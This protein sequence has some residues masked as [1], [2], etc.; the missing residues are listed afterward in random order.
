MTNDSHP[1][2]TTKLKA[3]PTSSRLN[4]IGQI[5]P[6]QRYGKYT[7][8]D[9]WIQ[10][11][12]SWFVICRCDC[13]LEKPQ[14]AY[15][16]LRTNVKMCSSCKISEQN[17]KHGQNTQQHITYEYHQWINLN[18][19]KRLCLEWSKSF[20]LFFKDTGKRPEKGFILCKIR[21]NNPLGKNNFYWGHPRN[22]FFEDIKGH[23]FG[24]WKILEKDFDRK[25]PSW[26]CQCSCGRKDY[27]TQVNLIKGISTKCKSC[28]A[29][30]NIKHNCSNN[31]LYTLFHSI[32]ARCYNKNHKNYRHYGG[33]GI[34]ICDRWL[35]SVRF[36]IEDMGPRPSCLH[37]IDRIDN[38]GNYCP[39]NCRWAT[40]KEQ[41]NNRRRIGDMQK[42]IDQLK[43]QLENK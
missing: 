31:Y 20:K 28:A 2:T 1:S 14:S 26:L 17:F 32:K 37:S 41:T 23:V 16:L 22:R 9:K 39:E 5:Q 42:E 6:N 27:I 38:N 13:G 29:P 4:L 35:K 8:T 43:S 33:R 10:R 25:R 7:T 34:L 21:H 24:S 40:Q 18:H 36:F 3:K 11:G 15:A 12:S 30:K 19:K